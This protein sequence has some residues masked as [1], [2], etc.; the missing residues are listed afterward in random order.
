MAVRRFPAGD[1]SLSPIKS[2]TTRAGGGPASHS[3]DALLDTIT[4]VETPEHFSFS[5]E[6]AGPLRRMAAYGIDL[7]VRGMVLLVVLWVATAAGMLGVWNFDGL[8]TGVL[9]LVAFLLEWGYFVV[10]ELAWDGRSVG[11]RI[12]RLRV[13]SADGRPLGVGNVLLRNLL[14]AADF[15]PSAYALGLFVMAS[16]PQFRRLGDAVA[17]TL[18]VVERRE[19]IESELFIDPPPSQAELSLLPQR[20]D[21]SAQD[22]E[23]LELFLRRMNQYPEARL[24][25]LAELIAPTY[26]RRVGVRYRNP[27]RFLAVL[28]H[29]A[30][31]LRAA[32]LPQ[33]PLMGGANGGPRAAHP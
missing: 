33:I 17:G 4:R 32:P 1:V 11:K 24:Y 28:Y 15:L 13:V 3:G 16:D 6:L 25:E 20:P 7:V 2:A 19:R 21:L 9:L 12:L 26:A 29:R 27:V 22:L 5:F 18:V 10:L 8:A 30:A 31:E 14:R 23:A